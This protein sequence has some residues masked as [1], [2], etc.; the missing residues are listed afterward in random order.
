[1]GVNLFIRGAVA[2]LLFFR[3]PF[4]VVAGALLLAACSSHDTLPPFTQTGYLADAGSVRIWRKD[5]SGGDIHILSAFTPWQDDATTRSEYRWHNGKLF[6]I[7]RNIA[8]ATPD[9]VKLRFADNGEVS[10]MQRT[11][12]GQKLLV[13]NSDIAL[14]QYQAEQ[15]QELSE[16]LRVGKVILHQGRLLDDSRVQSCEGEITTLQFD[17]R[18]RHYMT[19]QLQESRVPL[20]I[21]WLEAPEGEQLLLVTPNDICSWQPNP[22]TF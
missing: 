6:F 9:Q 13:S 18:T 10:F 1:M 8:G 4:L 5:S 22:N 12:A 20:S 15:I 2:S 3:K 14:Y 21:A 16:A 7:E 17:R 19:L 11:L